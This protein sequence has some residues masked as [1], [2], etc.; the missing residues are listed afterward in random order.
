MKHGWVSLADFVKSLAPGNVS[1]KT[2]KEVASKRNVVFPGIHI[3]R[4]SHF[5]S[6]FSTFQSYNRF[7]TRTL[8]CRCF[9]MFVGF[10][11]IRLSWGPRPSHG[12][13]SWRSTRLSRVGCHEVHDSWSLSHFFES[14]FWHPNFH[15]PKH[16]II[17][18]HW[19]KW[20][21]QLPLIE[22]QDFL[23]G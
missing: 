23:R 16:I 14:N 10:R 3:Q 22:F 17:S 5:S 2:L 19:K 9:E 13:R 7:K 21:L 8:N 4:F 11:I 18:L 6:Q 15:H 20:W 12:W 1:V